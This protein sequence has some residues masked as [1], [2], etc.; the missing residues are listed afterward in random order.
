MYLDSF[1]LAALVDELLDT[2]AGGRIQDVID[3]DETGIGLEIYGNHRRH[4]LYLSANNNHPRVHLMPD[5]LRRGLPKPTQMGLLMRRFVEGGTVAHISQPEWER[6]V[7]LD[8]EGAEGDI[9]IVV[10]PMER[11]ANLL[12]LKDGIIQDCMR[13]V[14]S[15]VNRY[16][17]LLPNQP[18]QL[19]PPQTSKISPFTVSATELTAF[20]A[21]AEPKAKAQ[22]ALTG[23]LLG[24]SPLLAREAL[25]AAGYSAD[26]RADQ[27]DAGRI[28]LAL[29]SLI[30]ALKRREWKPGVAE[31]PPR[32]RAFSVYPLSTIPNWR[33]V[34]S[35]SA[36]LAWYYDAPVG[37]DAYDAA[38]QPVR[39]AIAEG[40]AKLSAKIAS[41]S[42]SLKD[43]SEREALRQSGELILAYQY[44][45][46]PNQ[47]ELRA[48]YDPDAPE[49]VIPLDTTLTPLE[50]AQRYFD[51]YNR[52]KRALEDVPGLLRDTQAELA[53]VQQLATDLELA[54]NWPEIDEVQQALQ[55][56]GLWRGKPMQK[57]GG[58]KSAPLRVVTD[59]QFVI[60]IG[61]NSRQNE[62]VTFD[63]G[64]PA[65]LWLHARG[66][67]GAH[68]IIKFDGRPFPEAVIQRAA[69]LAAY[70]SALQA[71]TR[72][73]VDV[74]ERRHVKKMRSGGQGM[75]TYRNERTI[76][77]A[78]EKGS[79]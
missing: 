48:Q 54:S 11:R 22:Q 63:K 9:Q 20:F 79:A 37:I 58:G 23:R 12:L 61:R 43:D 76:S 53:T 6:I 55:A 29:Q 44:T 45:L 3:V 65:D 50:N 16:R 77:V 67:P 66:V 14:P 73:E 56:R 25:H 36:A 78:P 41:L 57:I 39:D 40:V 33:P 1:T 18:Y 31:N 30:E 70:Y 62:Q 28:F 7:T 4:Y 72:A 52:A 24:V 19:P 60:W 32:E 49:M 15:Q 59:D 13:R 51:R 47:T 38:K 2:I 64:S 75:V 71:E 74:T 35:V 21:E 68:V 27:V 17:T 42:A 26:A 8:V 10:E 69:A 46:A 34:E 5:K